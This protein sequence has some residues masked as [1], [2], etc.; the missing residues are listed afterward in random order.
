MNC[1]K[2]HPVKLISKEDI[3]AMTKN[4]GPTKTFIRQSWIPNIISSLG[5]SDRKQNDVF[6]IV[7]SKLTPL[8][9]YFHFHS[10]QSVYQLSKGPVTK[11]SFSSMS[12]NVI[13]LLLWYIVQ[14]NEK[15]FLQLYKI[16]ETLEKAT[17]TGSRCRNYCIN[18]CFILAF[19]I[20]TVFSSFM[21]YVMNQ[22]RLSLFV[23]F[24]LWGHEFSEQQI[25]E[26]FLLFLSGYVYFSVYL[27]P[28]I[29]TMIYIIFNKII[30]TGVEKCCCRNFVNDEELL[31]T[32]KLL[33]L[34]IACCKKVEKCY[35]FL[36]SLILLQY[37]AQ[38]FMAISLV[39]EMSVSGSRWHMFEVILTFIIC[40]SYFIAIIFFASG[41]P[42]AMANAKLQFQMMYRKELINNNFSNR[43]RLLI[44]QVLC[45]T[46]IGKL[47]AC[48][49]LFLDR[50][51][52][53]SSL[54]CFL[55]Y[56]FLLMQLS[57]ISASS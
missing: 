43:R 20:P 44:L 15:H 3:P 57:A 41:V 33:H 10:C 11:S 26:N 4:S 30:S 5:L 28:S 45:D 55:T 49:T 23:K 51:L 54:G 9:L 50:S 1:H 47:S 12:S 13:A 35:A 31:N 18:A 52:I 48:N 19:L 21:V 38:I 25:L 40:S 22:N 53:I 29:F 24:W 37:S 56:G 17:Y 6:R 42:K 16:I 36:I 39:V 34:I 7:L 46:K 2:I 27:S 8:V 14:F 32:L